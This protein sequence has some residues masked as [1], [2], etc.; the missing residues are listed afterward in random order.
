[1]HI[2]K[3]Q[4]KSKRQIPINKK[5]STKK[6]VVQQGNRTCTANFNRLNPNDK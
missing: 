4:T 5:E 2:Y 3:L 6:K 1:M